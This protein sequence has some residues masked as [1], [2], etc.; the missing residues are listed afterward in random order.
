MVKDRESRSRTPGL[1][2]WLYHLLAKCP[3]AKRPLYLSF[4]IFKIEII[5]ISQGCCEE[6]MNQYRQSTQNSTRTG[7]SIKKFQ[8]YYYQHHHYRAKVQVGNSFPSFCMR[9]SFLLFSPSWAACQ[10][11]ERTDSVST[12]NTEGRH[13]YIFFFFSSG[14]LPSRALEEQSV[15]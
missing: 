13:A 15:K 2:S 9:I 5:L 6:Q 11:P 10:F 1:E 12:E 8:L 7:L 3:W 14:P 4:L